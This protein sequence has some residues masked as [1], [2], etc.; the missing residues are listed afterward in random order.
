M[1]LRI[2]WGKNTWV[3]RL[4]AK[5]F[6]TSYNLL[7]AFKEEVTPQNADSLSNA[8]NTALTIFRAVLGVKIIT[9]LFQKKNNDEGK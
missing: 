1:D 2:F 8:F 9:D 5:Q 4:K 6:E 7:K 3:N